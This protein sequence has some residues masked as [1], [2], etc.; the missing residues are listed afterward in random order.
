L[1]RDLLP[2]VSPNP[3]HGTVS[4]TVRCTILSFALLAIVGFERI[5]AD[6]S[7]QQG[8]PETFRANL[9]VEPRRVE[10][11]GSNRQQHVLVTA[12]CVDGRLLDVTKLCIFSVADPRVAR[13]AEGAVL[14]VADGITELSVRCGDS[15]ATV[16]VH[17]TDSDRLRPVH[18]GNDVVPI[19]A[20]L[21]C[22]SG[23]CH[24]KASG[25]NGFKLSV[26][27]FDP[28][29]D[30]DAIVKEARGRRIFPA[31][32]E[33]SLFLL[34]PTAQLPHGGGKRLEIDSPDYQTLLEWIRQGTPLGD[35]AAP[36]LMALRVVPPERV[37]G[38]ESEQQ[39]LTTA[40]YSDGSERDVTT[41]AGYTTNSEVVAEVNQ[42]GVVRTGRVPGEAAITVRYMGQV[43][44]AQLQVPR[45]VVSNSFSAPPINNRVDEL[46]WAKLRKLG[47]TPSELSD[48]A[49]FLRRLFVDTLGTL[50]TSDEVRTFLSD[51]SLDK[52]GHAIDAVLAREEYAAYWAIKWADILLIDRNKLGERGAYEFH[53]WLR[54]QFAQ[55]R[56]YDQWVRELITSTGDTSRNGP[57]NFYRALRSPEDVTKA[58]SQA[59]LGVRL[60][61]AQCHHHP[62]ERWGQADFYGLAGFFGGMARKA[63]QAD[64]PNT[65]TDPGG[66]EL[67]YHA[68]LGE[69]RIPYFNTIVE[70][71]P[72][73]GWLT[74]ANVS[75]GR[76]P[77]T[78]AG[79]LPMLSTDDPRV[80]L[81]QWLTAPDN[82]WFARLVANRIWKNFNG[83]G[84]VDPEDD[85]R[86]TN[87]ATNAPLLDYLA[88]YLTGHKYDLKALMRL[89]LNSRTYQ[90]SSVPNE[91]NKDDV[92]NF[93]H[94]AVKRLPAEVLL[95][96]ISDVTGVPEQF[97]GRPPGTRAIQLWDNRLPSY[98]LEI[99]G[100]PERN[101]PCECGR[102]SEPT[103]AQALHLMNASEVM[104]KI[105]HETG[106]VSKVLEMGL[107]EEGVVNEL[108]LAALG[109]PAGD[110]EQSIAKRLFADGVNDGAVQ[111]FLW[112]LLNSYEF[113]FVQ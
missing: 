18:F 76:E 6:G 19:L 85:L 42:S 73:G 25:Q 20:K 74:A 71:R 40:I 111:D 62:F 10:L 109:R 16:P 107:S 29:A 75:D 67:I 39:I 95:D 88:Q 105:A 51:P 48:D 63:I 54:E 12:E 98:F 24:G 112:T 56:P 100:R 86:S 26:F 49:T 41:A 101:S 52:R 44:A 46:V 60:E 66:P 69:T 106:R 99:F 104:G 30:F 34:K 35:E 17:V 72:P 45:A 37:L 103:M 68:G 80:H 7:T 33:R 64:R 65:P 47:I 43:S 15:R 28:A 94:Y 22:N 77:S 78:P 91:L 31:S 83:R 4:A 5:Y 97:T 53:R 93:S 14:G 11:T 82:P 59:F 87:P 79:R 13:V 23:G 3:W 1:A 58:V 96:A 81:A 90:L 2:P 38:V 110:R 113:V 70:T 27:G 36:Q 32:P 21:G 108:C 102:S 9:V 55:N 57:V 50:P 92:Q 8:R 61:C 89:I 84:L